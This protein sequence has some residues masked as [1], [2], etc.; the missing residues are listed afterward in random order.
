MGGVG[1][2]C[3]CTTSAETATAREKKDFMRRGPPGLR[4]ARTHRTYFLLIYLFAKPPLD[5]GHEAS[6]LAPQDLSALAPYVRGHTGVAHGADVQQI[7]RI[8]AK[9]AFALKAFR[10]YGTHDSPSP[11]STIEAAVLNG[12]GD[13]LRT[14]RFLSG[15]IG[16]RTGDL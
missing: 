1:N 7:D 15:Q 4:R 11:K 5:L 13:V 14:D 9:I 2:V 3:G 12:L 6:R 16:N 8:V 10:G